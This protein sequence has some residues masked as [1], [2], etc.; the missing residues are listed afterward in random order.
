MADRTDVLVVGGGATGVGVARDLAMRDVDVTLVERGGLNAGTSGRSHGVLHSGA[1]YADTDPTGAADCIA[2]NR[3]LR[4]IAGACVEST[5][6]YF[7]QLESDDPNFFDR[8]REACRDCGI[9]VDVLDG[10]A[11]RAAEPRLAQNVERVLSVPDGVVYP[12]RLVA[13][14]AADAR[15][16]GATI[17]THAPVTDL[18]TDGDR[19]TG[20]TVGGIGRI[21]A[22]HVVNA[23]G[24][25]ADQLAA[26]VGIEL[27]M[28]PTKGVMAAVDDDGFGTDD[29]LGAVLNRCRPASDGDIVVPHADRVVPG[30]TS[31]EVE[32]PEEFPEEQW[33]LERVFAECAAM[34]PDLSADRLDRAYWGVRPLY[35]PESYGEDA[36]GVSRDFFL[37]NHAERDDV[38]GFTTIVGGKLTTHRLMAEVTADHVA[39][40]LGVDAPSRTADVPLVG[41]DDPDR[42]DAFVEEFDATGPADADVVGR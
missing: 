3:V 25:W 1:R 28:H 42:L 18:H 2:E 6:G 16:H 37:L 29:G 41:H 27:E 10:D 21:D 39:E 34:L 31:V 24:A 9:P 30:T 22:G 5:G 33:E 38:T 17:H 4:E 13:A 36:R 40:R 8:K 26:T 32:D 35:S 11:A 19:L 23:T 7:V 15:E 14:T 12:S 20:A